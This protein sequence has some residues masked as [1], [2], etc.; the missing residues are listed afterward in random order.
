MTE[1][2]PTTLR[3]LRAVALFEA[4]KGAAVLLAGFGVLFVVDHGS[5]AALDALVGH[6]HLNPAKHAP[7]IFLELLGDTS[8]RD[9]QGLAAGA[10]A[11]AALRLTEAFGLWHGRAWAAWIAIASGLVYVP[12]EIAGLAHGANALKVALLVANLAIVA[13]MV[14]VLRAQRRP[15]DGAAG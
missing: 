5:V 15:G 7:R 2:R 4:A 11:Y 14:A 9:L 13:Y 1:A 6:L 8:N 3:G 10:L 12:F